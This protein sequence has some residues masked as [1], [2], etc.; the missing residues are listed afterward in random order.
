MKKLL[1]LL[2]ACALT[3]SVMLTITACGGKKPTPTP[4]PTP[5]THNYVE[6]KC[7]C[8]AVDPNYKPDPNTPSGGGLGNGGIE[9][10][11]IDVPSSDQLPPE[12]TEGE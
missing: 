12:E 6:G 10:P 1:V 11:P 5:H 2:L 8:G 7:E 9:L 4:T 3:L